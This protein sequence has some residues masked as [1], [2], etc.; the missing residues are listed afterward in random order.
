MP[1]PSM[2]PSDLYLDPQEAMHALE[3]TATPK[4]DKVLVSQTKQEDLTIAH[5]DNQFPAAGDVLSDLSPIL[6]PPRKKRKG[7]FVGAQFHSVNDHVVDLPGAQFQPINVPV[8]TKTPD[9]L[10]KILNPI[11]VVTK[12]PDWLSKILNP[13]TTRTITPLTDPGSNASFIANVWEEPTGHLPMLSAANQ[14]NPEEITGRSPML[15]TALSSQE[16]SAPESNAG[17]RKP[18]CS[19]PYISEDDITANLRDENKRLQETRLRREERLGYSDTEIKAL[20]KFSAHQGHAITVLDSQFRA[21]KI[22]REN[23]EGIEN[24]LEDMVDAAIQTSIDAVTTLGNAFPAL[25]D[26]VDRYGINTALGETDEV[27]NWHE[28][29]DHIEFPEDNPKDF[30]SYAY[31][32]YYPVP[33]PKR[34]RR[35][36]GP[37]F[38]QIT[39]NFL[40]DCQNPKSFPSRKSWKKRRDFQHIFIHGPC[41]RVGRVLSKICATSQKPSF[42]LP[43]M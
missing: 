7:D 2:D 14:E 16:I 36:T 34:L 21:W 20:V 6:S 42:S 8:V 3:V 43:S 26:L 41:G 29:E 38:S 31:T 1:S 28:S 10:T 25:K 23:R 18:S 19:I 30:P 17:R 27:E 32:L 33:S 12:T 13:S 22:D 40:R 9:W 15:S 4:A 39:L 5:S 37:R 24:E 35:S 11:P